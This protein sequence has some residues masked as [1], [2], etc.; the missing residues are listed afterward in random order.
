VGR[1]GARPHPSR[2][3]VGVIVLGPAL[4][5]Y[6]LV[7][8]ILRANP[9]D[10]NIAAAAGK[11]IKGMVS[12][13]IY[14]AGLGLASSAPT[15]RTPATLASRCSASYLTDG[16]PRAPDVAVIIVGTA[17]MPTCRCARWTLVPG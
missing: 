6:A 5:Y 8:A 16:S 11:D 10:A 17:F 7:R 3:D 4:A 12:A 15:W 13:I 9:E 1:D 2:G 14:I